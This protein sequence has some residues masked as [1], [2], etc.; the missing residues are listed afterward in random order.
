MIRSKTTLLLVSLFTVTC[1]AWACGDI[2]VTDPVNPN[3]GIEDTSELPPEDTNEPPPEDTNTPDDDDTG[4]PSI[5]IPIDP[6]FGDPAHDAD[7][8]G[9]ST[10]LD[11]DDSDASVGTKQAFYADADGDNYGRAD[12]QVLSCEAPDGYGQYAGDCNDSDASINPGATEYCDGVDNDCNPA[13]NE[14]NLV[15]LEQNRVHAGQQT[16]TRTNTKTQD[17]PN[18]PRTT[19]SLGVPAA[20]SLLTWDRLN[21][22]YGTHY[23]DITVNGMASIKGLSNGAK[24]DGSKAGTVISKFGAGTLSVFDLKI[25]NG[26]GT[27]DHNF[28]TSSVENVG[29]GL[30]CSEG[31]L[32]LDGVTIAANKASRGG[33]VFAHECQVK[34]K[35][36]SV[37]SNNE[38]DR[39]GGAI[40]IRDAD[41]LV[42]DSILMSN[43][44]G[45]VAGESSRGG[46]IWVLNGHV[47]IDNSLLTA[48]KALSDEDVSFGTGGGIMAHDS[49]IVCTGGPGVKGFTRNEASSNW[50][51]AV[52]LDKESS[53]VSD[54]C[55]FGTDL[56]ENPGKDIANLGA[57][58]KGDWYMCGKDPHFEFTSEGVAQTKRD[59]LTFYEYGDNADMTCSYDAH[60]SCAAH[61][62]YTCFWGGIR[63][64]SN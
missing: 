41:L 45:Y 11:C 40:Y 23:V 29:G 27:T 44:V 55:T 63:C 20:S 51:S 60:V 14:T 33:A 54:G 52:G 25:N 18:G 39:F 58:C 16:L 37:L 17:D 62:G 24:L 4:G 15:T 31:A 21:V 3:D 22:C 59:A 6:D 12:D 53:F 43:Q 5:T 1:L 2:Q 49:S 28:G 61:A 50:G 7:G 38:A 13:T 46:A 26:L 8:D 57:Q 48:N 42:Q 35:D 19:L 47:E 36:G 10:V 34:L 64:H 32:V 9:V 56:T 30:Y